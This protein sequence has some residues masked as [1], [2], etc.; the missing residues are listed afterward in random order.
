MI[1][2]LPESVI[3]KIA[4]GEVV[5]RPV[6]AIKELIEN[7]LDAGASEI[8]VT[9][10]GGGF[11]SVQVQDNGSGIEFEN[12]PLLCERFTT[13]K[14]SEFSDLEKVNTFGFNF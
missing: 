13:S 6:N 14:L 1:K 4:A 2:R 10:A 11:K 3:N 9:V 5:V 8:I 7:S 12:L